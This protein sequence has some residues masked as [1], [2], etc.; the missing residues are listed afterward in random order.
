MWSEAKV[1]QEI[2]STTY[3]IQQNRTMQACRDVKWDTYIV[4]GKLFTIMNTS[5]PT[6]NSLLERDYCIYELCS[7]IYTLNKQ[8]KKCY[9]KFIYSILGEIEE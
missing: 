7:K 1:E 3:F 5:H 9:I 6:R 2:K 8:N 4:V